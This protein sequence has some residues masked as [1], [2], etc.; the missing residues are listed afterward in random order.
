MIQLLE[1]D[2]GQIRKGQ[3]FM[4][5]PPP[6]LVDP[7]T[8]KTIKKESTMTPGQQIQYQDEESL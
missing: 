4:P 6:P 5:P 7:S 8:G 1:I 2:K 3:H